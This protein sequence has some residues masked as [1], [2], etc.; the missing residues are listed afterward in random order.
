MFLPRLVSG[1][2]QALESPTEALEDYKQVLALDPSDKNAQARVAVLEKEVAA[3]FEKQKDEMIGQSPSASASLVTTAFFFFALITISPSFTR[4]QA[5]GSRKRFAWQVWP[6]P[7]QLQGRAGPCHWLL[8]HQL[9]AMRRGGS[10]RHL[11]LPAPLALAFDSRAHRRV[12]WRVPLL[13]DPLPDVHASDDSGRA[14]CTQA[15]S[16]IPPLRNVFVSQ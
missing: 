6:E 8:Q 14:M 16:A 7:G 4:R 13:I 1:P 2:S 11:A 15:A 12:S 10:V 5:E 9:S 3:K